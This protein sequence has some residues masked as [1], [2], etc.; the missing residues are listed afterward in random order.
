MNFIGF[1][2][3]AMAGRGGDG[4]VRLRAFSELRCHGKG[5][6]PVENATPMS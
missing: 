4:K 5:Q 1:R 6:C 3:P 2:A